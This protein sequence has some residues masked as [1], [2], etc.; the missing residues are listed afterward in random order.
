[1]PTKEE[2]FKD[3]QEIM[4]NDYAGHIDKINVNYPGLYKITNDTD[5]HTFEETIQDYLLDFQDG[6]LW[7][8]SKNKTLPNRGFSV[9][10]YEDAL[11]VTEAPQENR[12]VIGDKI[13]K[14]DGED[15]LAMAL[16]HHKRLEDKLPERQKW[17]NVI[18]RST[19]IQV[20]RGE[21]SF[22]FNLSNYVPKPHQGIHTFKLLENETAFMQ[23]ENF[24]EEKPIRQMVNNNREVLGQIKN[25]IIDVRV[26]RGGNDEFYFSLLHYIFDRELQFPNLFAEDELMYTNYTER[27]CKLWI[28]ELRE[29][30]KQ[31]LDQSTIESLKEEISLFETNYGKGFQEVPEDTDFEI[32]GSSSPAHI[33]VLS[34]SYCGSSGDTFVSNAKKSPK[35]TVVGRATRGNIDYFNQVTVD[36]GDFEFW[37]G[38]SKMHSNYSINGKGVE[39]DIYIPWTPN[40]LEED[41][42][43]EYIQELIGKRAS[44]I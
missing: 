26:N 41:K 24:F 2:I 4:S 9:R 7:F 44:Q 27:N 12:I 23:I 11:Y 15:I 39:P 36:Y 18:R 43:L 10:R 14:I 28:S 8:A 37:Y 3:I 34:D 19:S 29:Y 33:Y 38:V 40:Q 30:M 1:M 13:I 21:E 16:K 17:D 6:H 22:E 31:E 42:D 5:D 20:K 25:L 35:V 32:K